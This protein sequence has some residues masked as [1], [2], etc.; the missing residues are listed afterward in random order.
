[1]ADEPE[2]GLRHR[3][4]PIDIS[5]P[6]TRAARNWRANKQP[7][8][9]Q[10]GEIEPRRRREMRPTGTLRRPARRAFPSNTCAAGNAS[11]TGC[12][13][14]RQHRHRIEHRR[15]RRQPE[16]HRPGQRLR[17]RPVPQDQAHHPE[18]HPPPHRHQVHREQDQRHPEVEQVERKQYVTVCGC[19]SFEL[20]IATMDLHQH[21]LL[22]FSTLLLLFPRQ[23]RKSS[24]ILNLPPTI[25]D[26]QVV[27]WRQSIL[28][29]KKVSRERW[30]ENEILK[31]SSECLEV[32]R[33]SVS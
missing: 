28:Y 2:V 26:C 13:A 33:R 20:R 24:R 9:G 32:K 8:R 23:W 19:T 6:R 4:S 7:G 5:A 15:E 30:K 1:V 11:A 31:S 22:F 21:F 17:P 18:R 29:G 3:H 16:Q 10:P 27:G 25:I 12:N 14:A